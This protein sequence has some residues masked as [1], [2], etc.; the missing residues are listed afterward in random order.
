MFETDRSSFFPCILHIMMICGRLILSFTRK[1]ALDLPNDRV[2]LLKAT[3]KAANIRWRG[4]HKESAPDGQEVQRLLCACNTVEHLLSIRRSAADEAVRQLGEVLRE[5]YHSGPPVDGLEDRVELASR[6]F[7]LHCVSHSKS[8]YL[9]ILI[10]DMKTIIS[11]C[12]NLGVGLA[13]FSNDLTETMNAIMRGVYFQHSSRGGGSATEYGLSEAFVLH[14]FLLNH[15]HLEAHGVPRPCT[16]RLASLD[17]SIQKPKWTKI[18]KKFWSS[19]SG[20]RYAV[21]IMM[22]LTIIIITI[23]FSKKI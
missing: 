23:M 18:S 1:V 3:F 7:Q 13:M 21:K 2:W 10:H 19:R 22:T 14:V 12:R 6:N 15:A 8:S 4:L 16:S 9:Y 20:K 5:L 11:K 17:R